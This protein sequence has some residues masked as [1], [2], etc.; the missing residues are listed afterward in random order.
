MQANTLKEETVTTFRL[1]LSKAKAFPISRRQSLE[2]SVGL[3]MR[4]K[5][6]KHVLQQV[7]ATLAKDP[8]Y[9]ILIASKV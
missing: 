5:T 4:L 7:D 8:A 3:S 2:K 6:A 1:V 9:W